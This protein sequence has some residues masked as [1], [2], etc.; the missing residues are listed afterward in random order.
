M[1]IVDSH[2]S[3]VSD[4]MTSKAMWETLCGRY[5][6][7]STASNLYL[8]RKLLNLR[9]AEGSSVEEHLN[10]LA[11]ICSQLAS[12]KKPLTND[13]VV[14]ILLN[15][16]P[17]SWELFVSIQEDNEALELDTLRAKILQ[18]AQKRTESFD[19]GEN[20]LMVVRLITTRS[21]PRR[22]ISIGVLIARRKWFMLLRTVTR[23]IV[24]VVVT[25]SKEIVLRLRPTLLLMLS[26]YP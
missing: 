26:C 11:T 12:M 7:Q 10:T 17:K 14:A 15:S 19:Y 24:A 21:T 22:I 8:R 5:E 2:L 9:L 16:L 1:S 3:Q 18:E 4:L 25:R 6:R 13:E 23:K 20:A